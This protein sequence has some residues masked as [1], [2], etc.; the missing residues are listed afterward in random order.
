MLKF[1]EKI[2]GLSR[3]KFVKALKAELPPIKTREEEGVR[4]GAGYVLPLYLEPLY[5]KKI[6]YGNR[7][8]PFKCPWY[9]GKVNYRKGLCPITERIQEKELISCGIMHSFLKK[10]DLDDVIKAFEKVYSLRTTIK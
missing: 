8:C 1:D 7:G 5:Q 9:K 6:A 4:I 2:V 10:K 3:D